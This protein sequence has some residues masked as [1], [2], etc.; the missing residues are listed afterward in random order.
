[1]VERHGLLI[2]HG[3]PHAALPEGAFDHRLDRDARAGALWG[4]S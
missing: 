1:L 4:G 2:A 3:E